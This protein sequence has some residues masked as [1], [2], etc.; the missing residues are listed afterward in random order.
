MQHQYE[1]LQSEKLRLLQFKNA[2]SKQI[3]ALETKIR[4]V[5]ILENIDLTK[6]IEELKSR[7]TKLQKLSAENAVFNQKLS[8]TNIA[9]EKKVMDIK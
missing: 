8:L 2:K 1:T 6:V 9:N 5:E 7:E 4:D 3:E